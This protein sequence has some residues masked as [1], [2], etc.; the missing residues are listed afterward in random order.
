[1]ERVAEAELMQDEAQAHAYAAADF[2]EPHSRFI[3]LLAERL[4]TLPS[5]GRALDLGCGPGDI[6]RRYARSFPGWSVDAVDGSPAMLELGRRITAESGLSSK[7]QFLE[8]FL[9]TEELP[10]DDYGLIFSNS[11]LHHLADPAVIW[12]TIFRWARP[13]CGVFVMDL[14]RPSNRDEAHSLVERYAGEE[15]E[16]LRTDFFNSLLA[17]YRP[18]EVEEQLVQADLTQLNLEVV[19]DRHFIVWGIRATA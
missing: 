6:A 10:H 12:S 15:P 9:P 13:G 14:L 5:P 7:I 3:A 18:S 16:V 4:S 17:A 1:M 11:L 8:R 2:S 19:S